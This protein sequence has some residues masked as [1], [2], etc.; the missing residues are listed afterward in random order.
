MINKKGFRQ[1]GSIGI[2]SIGLLLSG[3]Q[4]MSGMSLSQEPLQAYELAEITGVLKKNDNF[5]EEL[6][7]EKS[8]LY[9]NIE[10]TAKIEMQ[11]NQQEPI[12]Y[13]LRF[14]SSNEN[15]CKVMQDGTVRGI[16]LGK[17]TITVE[18]VFS[19]LKEKVVVWVDETIYPKEILLATDE[20]TLTEGESFTVSATVTPEAAEDVQILWDSTDE[21]IAVVNET[22]KITGIA[23]GECMITATARADETVTSEI[24]VRVTKAKNNENQVPNGNSG[25]GPDT[26]GADKSNTGNNSATT[27]NNNGDNASGSGVDNSSGGQNTEAVMNAYYMDSYAEQV[28]TIV[29]ARRAEV[30][31][32]PLTMNYTLV[33]AAKVRAAETVQSFSHTRPNGTS[34]FTAFDEAGVSYSGAGENI[35]AG[36]WSPDSVMNSWMNSEG[37]RA[38]IL[39]GSF[40]QIGIAC[41]YDSN[42]PYG[43]YWVQCFIN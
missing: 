42:S 34:C 35:A 38:N 23:E 9:L 11:M 1:I 14:S 39:D 32:A 7:A 19:G 5:L 10:E 22:G 33:S 30:G 20:V 28:L 3:C 24:S 15:I 2:V 17:A 31:L 4:N 43:Y 16:G 12:L 18:D 6:Q 21:T 25:S 27:G 37:H 41:Y 26:S 29:N 36:Q 40:T 8:I 13:R